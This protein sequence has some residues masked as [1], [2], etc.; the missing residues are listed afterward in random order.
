MPRFSL[1]N[2]SQPAHN[3]GNILSRFMPART[4]F[5]AILLSQHGMLD[6]E[7]N[8]HSPSWRISQTTCIQVIEIIKTQIVLAI[9]KRKELKQSTG[10]G[11][12]HLNFIGMSVAIVNLHFGNTIWSCG[13][14]VMTDHVREEID[15]FRQRTLQW[16]LLSYYRSPTVRSHRNS[17]T[18]NSGRANQP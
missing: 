17:S 15:S 3:N 7:P 4:G 9:K 1:E 12:H 2:L 11:L 16:V 10:M 13:I 5:I 6:E 8:G 14:F 18:G